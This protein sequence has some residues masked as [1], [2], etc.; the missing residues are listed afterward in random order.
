[1]EYENVDCTPKA[2]AP[3][4]VKLTGRPDRGVICQD[5]LTNLKIALRVNQSID[6]F[7]KAGV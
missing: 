4:K 1:M 3:P 2:Q 5:D 6:T 7:L